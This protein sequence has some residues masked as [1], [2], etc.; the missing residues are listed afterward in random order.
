MEK[1]RR[2]A[3]RRTVRLETPMRGAT[4]RWQRSPPKRLIAFL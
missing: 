4:A 2:A 3:G 1:T